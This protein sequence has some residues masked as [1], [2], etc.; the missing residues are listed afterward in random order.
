MLLSKS[1]SELLRDFLPNCQNIVGAG[2]PEAMHSNTKSIELPSLVV[3][4]GTDNWSSWCTLGG[5][6]PVKNL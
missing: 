4:I 6:S 5:T 2:L 1:G 3:W